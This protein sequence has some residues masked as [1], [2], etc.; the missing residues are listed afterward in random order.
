MLLRVGSWNIGNGSREDLLEVMGVCDALALQEAS[1]RDDYMTLLR[2][3]GYD[4]IRP[5]LPG[6][7]ATPLVYD[8]E[9]LEFKKLICELMLPSTFVGRG[10][11]PEHSK[12]KYIVGARFKHI[13]TGRRV[14]IV[15]THLVSGQ[16]SPLRRSAAD[17]HLINIRQL[18]WNRHGRIVVCGDFNREPEKVS[19][20]PFWHNN[21]EVLGYIPTHGHRS[22]DQVWMKHQGFSG[23]LHRTRMRFSQQRTFSNRSDHDA[24]LVTFDI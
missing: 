17:R 7:P 24:L 10:P 15:S 19:L 5:E 13:P 18:F 23:M 8:P 11:G 3:H 21:H 9:Q 2:E 22:I 16:D 12:P 6:A 4:V 1:D 20:G 14:T